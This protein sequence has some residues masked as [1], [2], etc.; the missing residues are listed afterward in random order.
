VGV[1]ALPLRA[2]Y[3]IAELAAAS[4]VERRRLHRALV[5]LG[6]PLLREDRTY[7][8]TLRDL[9]GR[10]RSLWDNILRVQAW[11]QDVGEGG[12]GV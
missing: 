5:R 9:E 1:K 6:V 4:G 11:R 10:G 7:L 12:V 2:M 8:V 3:T